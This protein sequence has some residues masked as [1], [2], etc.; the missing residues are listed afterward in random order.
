MNLILFGPPGAGKGTQAKF[1]IKEFSIPQIST[2]DILRANV[3]SGSA[4]GKEAKAYMDRGALVPDGIIDRMVEQ[5][6]SGTD[7]EKG[8]ILDGYPRNLDQARFLDNLL[9]RQE[10]CIDA[11]ISLK[12]DDAELVKRLSGRRMCRQCGHSFHI[13]F[14]PP[15]SQDQCDDCGGELYTRDDDREDTV[16]NRLRVYHEQTSSILDF[17]RRRCLTE[18]DGSGEVEGIRERIFEV[19]ASGRV[20]V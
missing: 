14:Q 17:Y 18:I 2:G 4:L 13:V 20:E 15:K 5:K 16:L 19:L 6:L 10:R 11:V 12:V 9:D 3:K 8:F 1:L 7:C